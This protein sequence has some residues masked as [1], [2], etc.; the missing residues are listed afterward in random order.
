MM[1]MTFKKALA[2]M[3]A[4]ALI[5]LLTLSVMRLFPWLYFYV[6]AACC[7]FYAYYLQHKP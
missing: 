2:A 7:A 5:I 3:L 4:L 1:A 6:F